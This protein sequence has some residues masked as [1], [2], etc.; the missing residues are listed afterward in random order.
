MFSG[1]TRPN[2]FPANIRRFEIFCSCLSGSM[3]VFTAE[4][5][6]LTMDKKCYMKYGCL[7]LRN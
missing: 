1:G 5:P 7:G 6:Q 2:S 3:F 4:Y